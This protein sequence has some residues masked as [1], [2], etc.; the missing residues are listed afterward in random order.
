MLARSSLS[1]S[2]G[3]PLKVSDRYWIPYPVT[4]IQDVETDPELFDRDRVAA[5]ADPFRDQSPVPGTPILVATAP[6]P[7]GLVQKPL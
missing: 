3:A 4:D 2:Y 1:W 6:K 5:I 7:V